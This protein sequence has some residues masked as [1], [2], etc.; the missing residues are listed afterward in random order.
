MPFFRSYFS[1]FPLN[2]VK[3][4]KNL[5]S[6]KKVK[7]SDLIRQTIRNLTT[8]IGVKMLRRDK[9]R[10]YQ[11]YLIDDEV[12]SHYLGRER[13]FFQLF[14]EYHDSDGDM[15]VILSKQIDYITRPIPSL[16]FHQHIQQFLQRKG[17]L[18]TEQGVY[19]NKYGNKSWAKLRLNDSHIDIHAKGNY[20]AETDFFEVLRKNERFFLAIDLINDRFGWLKPI[21]ERKFI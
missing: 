10:T 16:E 8:I 17:N 9:V 20:D 14:K 2:I 11:L 3:A 6:T 12:A 21:K 4:E 13:M 15:K 1:T 19:Y 5:N 7:V 18:Q